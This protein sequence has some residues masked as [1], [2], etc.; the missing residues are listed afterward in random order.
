M[1]S[2]VKLKKCLFV[3]GN[4]T[5]LVSSDVCVNHAKA[6]VVDL[7]WSEDNW[8]GVA[9]LPKQVVRL[10][11]WVT[12]PPRTGMIPID[13]DRDGPALNLDEMNI[14]YLLLET[15]VTPCAVSGDISSISVSN[16]L[17]NSKHIYDKK[18]TP[19]CLPFYYR[20]NATAIQWDGKSTH[21]LPYS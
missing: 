9:I 17:I 3:V 15:E 4:F 13:V 21:V 16:P 2:I 20:L 8:R 6:R 10:N 12:F 11:S 1:N 14:V 19:V 5:N 18:I 7:L